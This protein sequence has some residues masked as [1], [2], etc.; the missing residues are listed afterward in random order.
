MRR[1]LGR[2]PRKRHDKM[3]LKRLPMPKKQL[4]SRRRKD[5]K[6]RVNGYQRRSWRRKKRP[7]QGELPWSLQ[8][9]YQQMMKVMRKI[10]VEVEL[11]LETRRKRI[12]S[13]NKLSK[14]QTRQQITKMRL[15][16]VEMAKLMLIP[17]QLLFNQSLKQR[18]L[19]KH[20]PSKRRKK[21]RK[22][23][24]M[25]GKMPSMMSRTDW[26]RKRREKMCP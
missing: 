23:N 6:Q 14:K 15:R 13:N 10:N 19:I 8:V 20:K 3:R 16:M 11:W 4:S 2:K 9:W 22:K 5:Y 25:I 26:L 17:R 21:R 1:L 12:R 7:M 24:L 18:R